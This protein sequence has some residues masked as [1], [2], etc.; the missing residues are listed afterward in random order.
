MM[1]KVSTRGLAIQAGSATA[2]WPLPESAVSLKGL[3]VALRAARRGS[4]L[5]GDVRIMTG[6]TGEEVRAVSPQ[7]HGMLM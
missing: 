1:A 3:A 5:A 4:L 7:Y 6:V 2:S